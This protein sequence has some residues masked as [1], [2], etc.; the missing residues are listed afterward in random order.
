[1]KLLAVHGSPRKRGNSSLLLDQYLK[2][3]QEAN[4]AAEIT[5]V[6]LQEKNIRNCTA[7]DV[8]HTITPGKCVIKDDMQE[9]YTL[10]AEAS[11]L[12]YATPVY[13]WG[14]SAQLKTFLDRTNAFDVPNGQYFAGKKLALL[15][16]YG[17]NL[18][19]KGPE[20]IKASFEEI[21]EFAKMN[22]VD[23]YGVCANKSMPVAENAKVLKDVYEMGR[24]ITL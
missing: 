5:K 13:W 14:V 20:L 22:L 24:K 18:P 3:I 21:C 8:C 16:T 7:C 4:P 10:F 9:L 23:V 6:Y 17:I 1:M 15:M 19:N 11:M 2:G 12:V